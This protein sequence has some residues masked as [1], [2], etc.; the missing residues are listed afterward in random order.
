MTL[1]NSKFA[2]LLKTLLL[3]SLLCCA[4]AQAALEALPRGL[5]ERNMV[6]FKGDLEAIKQ[7]GFIRVLTRNTPGCY[8]IHRG[9]LVGFEYELVKHF[10]KRHG[11]EVVV[12]VPPR[13]DDMA[14]WLKDGRA[15]MAA[16]NIT[17][18]A[19]RQ[20]IDGLEFCHPYGEVFEMV[21]A[22]KDGTPIKTIDDLE[23]RTFHVR[24]T[25]SYFESLVQL[26]EQ[27]GVDYTVATVP[28]DEE[29]YDILAKV[30]SGEYDL[31]LADQ[32]ILDQSR[33]LGGEV[34]GVLRLNRKRSYGWVVRS[35]QPG[36][37][38]A[39]NRFFT[40]E[41]RGATFNTLYRR[42]FQQGLPEKHAEGFLIGASGQIS[43]FDTIVKQAA[44][45]YRIPWTLICA[46]MYQE[47]RFDPKAESWAGAQGLM[48][49]MPATAKELGVGDAFNPQDNIDGG[50]KYL[51]QQYDR[52]SGGVDAVDRTSFALA[53]YNGGYGHL[54]DAR[55]L[56]RQLGHNPDAWNS[57][58]EH[59]YA[60]LS[61]P[62]YAGKARYGYC[63]SGEI[64]SYVTKTMSRYVAY[65]ASMK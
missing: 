25:S 7:R 31:T 55:K 50:V 65:D 64:I 46:Q 18:T 13:W 44:E 38:A 9:E 34:K 1:L 56:A 40:A 48:Q 24:K 43:P 23:G 33:S 10:A 8:F 20:N 49:L 59:A 11:L 2:R 39:I 37:Q 61:V 51:R 22:R 32:T 58:V 60:L 30:G 26:K 36:L 19:N 3:I 21:V 62:E 15:D 5:E 29:T 54:L 41:N 14:G 28:E 47:S 4:G 6:G 17:V 35:G 27:T 57:H 52:I 53:A 63:R 42:Y 16:A 12:M 45:K